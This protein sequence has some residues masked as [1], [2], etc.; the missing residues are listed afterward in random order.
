MDFRCFL[1]FLMAYS[2]TGCSYFAQ[3]KRPVINLPTTWPS[4]NIK[5]RFV[6]TSLNTIA[7]W[8]AF[9]DPELN[10]LISDALIYN[11]DLGVAAG[12]VLEAQALLQKVKANWLPT[13]GIGETAFTGTI[14]DF[15]FQPHGIP[16]PSSVTQSY[17][18]SFDGYIAG[19]VPSYT[20]NIMQQLKMGKV[21]HLNL[22]MQEAVTNA[23]RLGV[24]SQVA[25]SYFSLIGLKKQDILQKQLIADA[26]IMR[27]YTNI[28]CKQGALSQNNLAALDQR[29]A[30]LQKQLPILQSDM[31][32]AQNA[33][34]V[35]LDR[36]LSSVVPQHSFDQ[37]NNAVIVPVNLPAE[38]LKW[39]PDV[40]IAEYQ[41]QISHAM[42]GV[43]ASHFFPT[44]NLSGV[45]G[46][47][48]I[49]FAQLLNF[50]KGLTIGQ[51]T[52]NL[53]LLNLSAYAEI[54]KEK[55]RKYA[56]YYHYIK[57]VRTVLAE[58]DDA[59]SQHHSLGQK[60]D[61]IRIALYEAT[62]Q[63]KA[64]KQQYQQGR[65]SYAETLS[66]KINLDHMQVMLN[67][68]KI[69]QMASIVNLYHVLGGGYLQQPPKL[70][71]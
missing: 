22:A 20:L 38:V 8:K 18:T 36:N 31:R 23:I 54:N 32:H 21:A 62:K 17:P 66:F 65:I 47:T 13:L 35:L 24:I 41:L 40:S 60:H 51:F 56:A 30:L 34:N 3:Y 52:S 45:I 57:T 44:I 2:L 7:W 46:V 63:Y 68:A 16:L 10:R 1:F 59:L 29:I 28:Q 4:Q 39:R 5:T 58:V 49:E 67:K 50:G 11:S 48:S 64:A 25:G 69:Q 53:P 15:Q 14:G 33:L 71:E 42:I 19:F 27:Q 43:A 12:N 37:I 26:K 70:T 55:G 6:P 61:Q 9:H